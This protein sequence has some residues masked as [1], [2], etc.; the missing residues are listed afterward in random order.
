[1]RSPWGKK[2]GP[3]KTAGMKFT[4]YL[5]TFPDGTTAK[6]RTTDTYAEEAVAVIYQHEGGWYCSCV[7]ATVPEWFPGESDAYRT[8]KV[9]KASG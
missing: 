6:K 1:M 7:K 8:V 3:G 4:T 2:G 5:V 9:R